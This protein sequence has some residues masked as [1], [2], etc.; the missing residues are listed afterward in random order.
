MTQTKKYRSYGVIRKNNLSDILDKKESLNNLLNNISGVDPSAGVTFISEDLDSIRGLKDTDINPAD[1]TQLAGSTPFT[2][3]VDELGNSIPDAGGSPFLTVINPLIRIQDRFKLYRNVTEDPPVFASG[4]G[5]RAYFIPSALLPGGTP[6]TAGGLGPFVK[7]STINGQLLNNLTDQRVK[8]SDDFWVLGEFSINDRIDPEFPDD[9]G[10]IM[11]EGYYIPNPSTTIHTF[12]YETSGLFHVEFDRFGNGTWE[13]LKSIYAKVRNVL[14]QTAITSTVITL[15]DGETRYVS[16]GDFLATNNAISITEVSATTITLSAAITVTAGQTLAFDMPIGSRNVSGIYAINEILDRA[17]TPQM[18]KRIFWWF[19]NTGN[20]FPDTKYLRNV[21]AGLTTYDYFYLNSQRASPIAAAGSIRNLL[22]TAI[23]PVQ[24][25]LDYQFKSR[26]TTTTLYMPKPFLNQ[27]TKGTSVISFEQGTRSATG[28]FSTT[29]VGNYVIP[30]AVADIGTVIPKNTR[31]KDIL[32]G[33]PASTARLVN[34]I[35]PVTRANYNVTFV[36]HVGLVDYFVITSVG[37]VNNILLSSGTTSKLKKDM[38]CVFNNTNQ[39]IRI[40]EI[41]S[42]TSFRTSVNLGLTNSYVYIYANS[43]IVD[44]SLD[45]FCIGVF[46]QVVAAQAA[47]GATTIQLGSTA[48]VANGMIVQFGNSILPATT[49]VGF[50][51]TTI[52]LSNPLAIA[53]NASETIIFAPA[54]TNVNKEICVRPIDISPPFVGVP[55][56]LDTSNK[57]IRSS[58]LSLNV[59]IEALT[60]NGPVAAPTSIVS[61]VNLIE[62]YDNKI[63]IFNSTLS[64]IAKKVV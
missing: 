5:P 23:T 35:W 2:Y 40:T 9:F 19:P 59:K 1:F 10:G 18:K 6:I 8:I 55:T 32:N 56:G 13:V 34:I 4:R 57:G 46:G 43:G 21:I 61:T 42:G 48:G 33:D 52:T 60:I 16:V 51:A 12:S 64:I 62:N 26:K 63:D 50:T 58:Q 29:E 14:V 22:D 53:I 17:E 30:T 36:D 15:Q 49:V 38:F 3:R 7:G 41:I 31:V 28:I 11:W 27:I 47:L 44:R 20:Y 37:N 24:D 25:L 54:E 39:F 45:V